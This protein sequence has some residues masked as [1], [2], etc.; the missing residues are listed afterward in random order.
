MLPSCPL[1]NTGE[2]EILCAYEEEER[3]CSQNNT[4]INNTRLCS[5][6]KFIKK[7]Y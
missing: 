6:K 5:V 1:G 7:L 4:I 2:Q 3:N